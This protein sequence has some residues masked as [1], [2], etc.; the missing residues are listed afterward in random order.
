MTVAAVILAAGPSLPTESP[1]QLVD[2]Q[3][4]PVLQR[5]VDS[6][7]GWGVDPVVV[8]L[9]ASAEEILDS[10]EFGDATVAINEGWEEGIASSLRVGLDIL[11]RDAALTHA[12]VALGDEPMIPSDVPDQLIDEAADP[13]RAA[14]VP[15]YR[16]ERGSPILVA[17]SLW[18][19]LMALDGDLS[20][21]SFLRAHPGLV[22]EVRVDHAPPRDVDSEYDAGDVRAGDTPGTIG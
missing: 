2:V 18:E 5:V 20:L 19:R 1:K 10:I 6:A 8:V 21:A 9:G 16:Y 7:L 22:T 17:R 14:I 11:S 3:G 15:V 13:N 12:I 4:R